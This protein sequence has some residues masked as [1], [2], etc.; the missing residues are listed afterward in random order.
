MAV[1]IDAALLASKNYPECLKVVSVDLTNSFS[2]WHPTSSVAHD[3]DEGLGEPRVEPPPT[4]LQL[5][6]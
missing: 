1:L 5:P 4:S 2:N 6:F 3:T